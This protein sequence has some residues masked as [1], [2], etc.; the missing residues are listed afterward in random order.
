MN[1]TI[2]LA[3]LIAT[4]SAIVPAMAT[5]PSQALFA[6][7]QSLYQ[8]FDPAVADMYCDEAVI[9]NQRT[10]PDG[11]QRTI[12]LQAATYKNVLR[13][14]MPMAKAKGDIST[15][16]DVKYSAEGDNVRIK[17]MRYSEMKRYESP[18]SLLVGRCADGNR[19]IL[20][21]LSH[22]RP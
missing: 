16:T 18:F 2:I 15:Y 9:R 20:E 1:T 10:Y 4:C 21:E 17:T 13:S 8:A 6:Q 7:Y 12:N 19:G 3:T 11:N 5:E 22:S 14:V